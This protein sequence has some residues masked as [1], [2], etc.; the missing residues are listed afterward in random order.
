[1]TS[2]RY[3]PATR[4]N[5]LSAFSIPQRRNVIPRFLGRGPRHRQTA[6]R[7]PTRV[8]C[9]PELQKVFDGEEN[10]SWLLCRRRRLCGT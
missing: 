8:D 9:T 10:S 2:P 6:S 1:M 5:R 3:L 4:G 7:G